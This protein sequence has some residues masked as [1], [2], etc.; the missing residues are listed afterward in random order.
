MIFEIIPYHSIGNIFFSMSKKDV[1]SNLGKASKSFL[2]HKEDKSQT[3]KYNEY[4]FFINYDENHKLETLE[5]WETSNLWLGD[6]NL[7]SLNTS[8]LLKEIRKLD[9]N[10]EEES[11][12]FTSFK[13]GIGGWHPELDNCPNEPFKS[14]IIFK[15]GYYD[16]EV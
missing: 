3:H 7:F 6:L 11:D 9:K 15:K 14:I 12:G 1:E 5:A 8:Q 16:D 4:S 2:R 13:L 10:I